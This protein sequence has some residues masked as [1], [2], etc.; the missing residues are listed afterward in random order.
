MKRTHPGQSCEGGRG[1]TGEEARGWERRRS[2][3]SGKEQEGAIEDGKGSRE[4]GRGR[5]RTGED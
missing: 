4:D 1:R 3:R 2:Y 5:E